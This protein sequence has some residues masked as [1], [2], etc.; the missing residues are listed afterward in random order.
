MM[1][2]FLYCQFHI[3]QHTFTSTCWLASVLLLQ[4]LDNF[5]LE[6]QMIGELEDV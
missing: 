4:N 2:A 3:D 6:W 1:S 5:F